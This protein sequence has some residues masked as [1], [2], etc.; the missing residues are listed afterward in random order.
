MCALVYLDS[1]K[2]NEIVLY[3]CPGQKM[4]T[5]EYGMNS[6]H[7]LGVQGKTK[8]F[9]YMSDYGWKLLKLHF[10]LFYAIFK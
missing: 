4:Q 8:E 7:D 5:I 6:I 2:C 9:G 10:L 1:T 3:F